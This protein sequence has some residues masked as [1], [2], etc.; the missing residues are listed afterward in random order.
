LLSFHEAIE[1][2]VVPILKE[3]AEKRAELLGIDQLKPW[4]MDVSTTG[5]AALKPFKNGAG[6]D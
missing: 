1:K 6:T 4:D 2:Q 3:Q 5:K